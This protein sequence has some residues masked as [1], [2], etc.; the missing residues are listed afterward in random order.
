MKQKYTK[1][2]VS[3]EQFSVGKKKP[4]RINIFAGLYYF[5]FFFIYPYDL[6]N[7]AL[8]ATVFSLNKKQPCGG[9]CSPVKVTFFISYGLSWTQTLNRTKQSTCTILASQKD[10]QIKGMFKKVQIC[11]CRHREL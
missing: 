6:E 2:S 1:H 3:P 7:I 8:K 9:K 11:I 5:F 10:S 4:I